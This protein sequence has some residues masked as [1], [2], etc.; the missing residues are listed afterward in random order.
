VLFAKAVNDYHAH[1]VGKHK[2]TM[3]MWGDRLLDD[4]E[5][6]YDEWEA[7]RNGTAP[8][9]DR[10]PRDI[11]VCDWHYHARSAY[12]S[13]VFFQDKGFRVW[14]SSWWDPQ[15]AEAFMDYALAHATHR[16]IGHLCTTWEPTRFMVPALLDPEKGGN[17]QA[18]KAAATLRACMETMRSDSYRRA[19]AR[20]LAATTRPST[21]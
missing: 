5:M 16:M 20:R 2:V 15:G 1:L 12:P 13:V 19:Y 4:R 10:I 8:A 6:K 3:L 14:P 9:V 11:I 17:D 21:R 18:R 7:S